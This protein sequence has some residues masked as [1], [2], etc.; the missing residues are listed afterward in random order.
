MVMGLNLLEH[1][2][3]QGEIF[4]AGVIGKKIVLRYKSPYI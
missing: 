2:H 1:D 4:D 3:W